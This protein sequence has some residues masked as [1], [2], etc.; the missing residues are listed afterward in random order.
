MF[1]AIHESIDR[2]RRRRSDAL[3]RFHIGD[4]AYPIYQDWEVQIWGTIVNIDPVAYK[5]TVNLNG[6][7]RQ[8]D[9]EELVL[10]S[11]E[12]KVN[13]PNQKAI[14]VARSLV[15]ESVRASL[16]KAVYWKE[17][18]SV[19]R[20]S[21]NEQ[22]EGTV[23]CPKCR[24]SMGVYFDKEL[25]TSKFV[26]RSCGK[27]ILV[28]NVRYGSV[29]S[30]EVADPAGESRAAAKNTRTESRI[31]Y[32]G[33]FDH[34]PLSI[35]AETDRDVETGAVLYRHIFVSSPPVPQGGGYY[36]DEPRRKEAIVRNLKKASEKLADYLGGLN[37]LLRWLEKN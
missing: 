23:R 31:F 21:Q 32:E 36:G 27:V 30:K 15:D 2:A 22:E 24:E 25:K 3:E 14:D 26:C 10:T 29:P 12:A 18:P 13:E 16:R 8:Y 6:I 17:K 19:F 37:N 20:V 28:R 9:P 7:E 4:V 5:I 33:S 11:P 34:E 35:E 1:E